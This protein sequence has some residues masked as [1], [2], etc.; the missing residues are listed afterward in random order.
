[1]GLRKLQ[2]LIRALVPPHVI[3]KG[4]STTRLLAPVL[5]AKYPD[6]QP[7]YREEGYFARAGKAIPRSTLA[8]WVGACGVRLQPQAERR[9]AERAVSESGQR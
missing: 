3:D 1:V 2:T 6:H 8:H 4:I 5:A 7:L 9:L